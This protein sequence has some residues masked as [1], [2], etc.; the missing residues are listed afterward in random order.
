MQ[1]EIE[2][3]QKR[4]EK[5]TQANWLRRLDERQRRLVANARLYAANDPA[6]MPGHQ[7]ALIVA[8]MADMLDEYEPECKIAP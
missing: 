8:K 5:Y 2:E 6:G 7:L 3:L 1:S 4:I